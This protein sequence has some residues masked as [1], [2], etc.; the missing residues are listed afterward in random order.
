[1][2][3]QDFGIERSRDA[4]RMAAT[5]KV[6]SAQ[7]DWVPGLQPMKWQQD[8]P[9]YRE[10]REAFDGRYPPHRL[11]LLPRLNKSA[12]GRRGEAC[13]NRLPPSRLQ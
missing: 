2:L 7:C 5:D 6:R 9:A 4:E 13:L 12:P 1:M 11:L 3:E 8:R 10:Y